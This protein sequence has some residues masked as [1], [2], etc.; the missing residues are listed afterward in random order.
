M[1]FTKRG[2]FAKF[3]KVMDGNFVLEVKK[4]T[5]GAEKR[6][7]QKGEHAG[8][9]IW[10][11]RFQGYEGYLVGA[12]IRETKFGDQLC[13]LMNDPSNEDYPVVTI[14]V[15]ADGRHAKMFFIRME[16][17]DLEKPINLAPW[18]MEK[19]DKETKKVIKGEFIHG[20]TLYQDDEKIDPAIEPDD[21][22]E[23][24]KEKKGG[25][26][27]WD[28]SEQN[29]FFH[30]KFQEWINGSEF[31][32]VKSDHKPKST[33]DEDDADDD[34]DDEDQEELDLSDKKKKKKK[35]ESLDEE[36]DDDDIPF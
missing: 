31:R 19:K 12:K 23:P 24:S 3:V 6:I 13:L 25:K 26:I 32:K 10:E 28:F 21:V 2:G 16:N 1:G 8:E 4:G 27:K 9:P 29:E 7:K 33:D 35:K 18:K 36:D 5:E 17:I 22:P 14:E 34:D 20:W 15:P 30:D 11:L